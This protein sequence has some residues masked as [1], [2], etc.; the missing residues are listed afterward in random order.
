[1]QPKMLNI[2]IYFTYLTVILRY[3]H[4]TVSTQGYLLSMPLVASRK[5]KT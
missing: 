4:L 5:P 2:F 3:R 1:M